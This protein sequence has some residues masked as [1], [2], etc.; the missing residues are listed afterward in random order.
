MAEIEINNRIWIEKNGLAFLGSG[1]VSLLESINKE[2]SI[3]R[4]AKAMGMSYKRAWQLVNT[5]NN[6]SDEPLVERLTGGIGGGG[7]YLTPKGLRVIEEFRRI[8]SL[9]KSLLHKELKKSRF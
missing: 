6:I 5:M 1:R 8:D 4:A 7:T 2:G 3:N 9:C